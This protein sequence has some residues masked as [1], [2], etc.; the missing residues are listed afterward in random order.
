MCVRSF[1]LSGY[2]ANPICLVL[3]ILREMGNGITTLM[4]LHFV[5]YLFLYNTNPDGL[6]HFTLLSTYF[7]L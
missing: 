3:L 7:R 1:V 5:F 4:L 2:A 6:I